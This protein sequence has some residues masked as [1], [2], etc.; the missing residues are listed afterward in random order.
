MEKNTTRI[1]TGDKRLLGLLVCRL[2]AKPAT[3]FFF[4][5]AAAIL[6]G[7]QNDH[8]AHFIELKIDGTELSIDREF[9]IEV[10]IKREAPYL[11]KNNGATPRFILERENDTAEL[12]QS[13]AIPERD[14]LH[15]RYRY[16]FN[17]TG[18][19]RFE[20]EL[21]WKRQTLELTPLDITVH[22]PRLS[23]HTPFVWTLYSVS[24]LPI[25]DGATLEQGTE[26]ILCLTAAFYS[27]G[28]T[29]R[30]RYALQTAS[31]Q[32]EAARPEAPRSE[33][34]L[35]G[36]SGSAG[37]GSESAQAQDGRS[38][39]ALRDMH[40]E[41]PLPAEIVRI[42]CAPSES[43]ALKPLTLAE[44]PFDAAVLIS[45]SAFP[46]T[47]VFSAGV[48]AA[49]NPYEDS[50]DEHYVLAMFSLIP[51]RIGVQSLPQAQIFF[52]AGG[53]AFSAPAAYR[54]DRQEITEAA[55]KSGADG[56]T[57]AAFQALPPE[58]QYN[59]S[60]MTEQEKSV[61]AKQIAE[62]R[63]Q[64]AATLFS[65]VI[66]RERRKLEAALEIAHP[67]PLYPRLLGILTAVV[68]GLL[69]IGAAVCGF[70]NKKRF[71][72]LCIIIALCSGSLTAVLFRL[73]L[74]P[75]GV[76]IEDT[77]EIAVRRIPENTGSIVHRLSAGDSVIIIRR[78]P[79]WYYIKTV[80]GVTGWILSQS[81][82]QYN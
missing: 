2:V 28:Y 72:L 76:C 3:I 62:Y 19:F 38:G 52:T 26:Y 35:S 63:K 5:C 27:A 79:Q 45:P 14:G 10:V 6:Y 46:D 42:E 51:L 58:T 69:L 32:I 64:E 8:A 44:L 31:A 17:K 34:G 71:M 59:G 22:R 16:R 61:A 4:F 13:S 78:A 39:A 20:P 12:I 56:F 23:E 53:K 55:D 7:Q 75:Q 66:R 49:S 77:G 9:E 70:R 74:R 65:P 60:T 21:Q 15:L 29:E 11:Q 73:I 82:V 43:A 36:V 40:S 24:G 68:S 25:A 47:G 80:G 54:I 48:P 67:L 33:A 30:Y 81:I 41:L 50:D 1:G 57:A 18:R 37:I